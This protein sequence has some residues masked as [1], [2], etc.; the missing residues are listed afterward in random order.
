MWT[1]VS[2]AVS[3]VK[4][5]VVSTYT[6]PADGQMFSYGPITIVKNDIQ[7][8]ADR[9]NQAKDAWIDSKAAENINTILT[10]ILNR[11]V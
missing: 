10:N 3:R 7:S 4:Y 6:D 11:G 9:A 1:V 8:F 2:D 5:N